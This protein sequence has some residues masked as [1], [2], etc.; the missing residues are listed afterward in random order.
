MS[1][2]GRGGIDL[3]RIEGG[4]ERKFCPHTFQKLPRPPRME[5]IV[6]ENVV[7]ATKQNT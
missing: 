2:M 3:R 5:L 7:Y 1:K 6:R 4:N